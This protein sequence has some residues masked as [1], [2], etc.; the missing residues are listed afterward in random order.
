MKLK[1][2]KDLKEGHSCVAYEE[3][4]KKEAIKWVKKWIKDDEACW[5]CSDNSSY[6]LFMKFHNI[7]ESDLTELEGGENDRISNRKTD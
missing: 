4:V 6:L 1:T 5:G 7:T 2:L 3:R